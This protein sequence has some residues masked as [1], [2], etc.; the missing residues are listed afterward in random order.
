MPERE[1]AIHQPP[2][3][4]AG[5]CGQPEGQR[6]VDVVDQRGATLTSRLEAMRV[7]PALERARYLDVLE[8]DAVDEPAMERF[9][10]DRHR[11]ALDH[12]RDA[13][14]VGN[15]AIAR[16]NADV[17]PGR[18]QALERAG[19]RVPG[20]EIGR[21]DV[22]NAA[23]FV[24]RHGSVGPETRLGCRRETTNVLFYGHL[25]RGVFGAHVTHGAEDLAF[26]R[27]RARS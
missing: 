9:P 12:H 8:L 14:A 22:E 13:R 3:Q 19:S 20:K 5:D 7:N 4:D 1:H 23:F 18:S 16:Q 24:S 6:E 2:R 17:L 11:A 25:A 26:G 15:P 27:P 21:R 10:A